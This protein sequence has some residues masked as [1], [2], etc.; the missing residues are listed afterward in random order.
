MIR[1]N[2]SCQMI[3]AFIKVYPNQIYNNPD[4]IYRKPPKIPSYLFA[5]PVVSLNPYCSCEI[6]DCPSSYHMVRYFMALC[7][8]AIYS[9]KLPLHPQAPLSMLVGPSTLVSLVSSWLVLFITAFAPF[10]MLFPARSSFPALTIIASFPHQILFWVNHSSLRSALP[11]VFTSGISFSPATELLIP[12]S[13]LSVAIP[14]HHLVPLLAYLAC[15][16][17]LSALLQARFENFRMD[18]SEDCLHCRDLQVE[19]EQVRTHQRLLDKKIEAATRIITAKY[20]AYLNLFLHRIS[21]LQEQFNALTNTC[22]HI[23]DSIDILKHM[24]EK[25]SAPSTRSFSIKIAEADS[26]PKD[27]TAQQ[28]SHI[29]ID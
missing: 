6:R 14:I 28:I 10:H 22:V 13:V 20:E 8:P 24:M 1:S 18:R 5:D 2:T 26:H 4:A 27:S 11:S 12:P 19:L 23:Q 21:S 3:C 9:G 17:L 29:S 15:E 16:S 25:I 7:S